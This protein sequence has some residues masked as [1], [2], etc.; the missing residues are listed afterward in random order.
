VVYGFLD[1]TDAGEALARALLH[2]RGRPDVIVLGL[3]RGGVPVAFEVASKLQLPLDVMVVRKLGLP[4]QPE[5]AMGALASGGG[6]VLN[7]DVLRYLPD[8]E[9]VLHLVQERE[10]LELTRR[11]HSYRGDRGA[12]QLS[13]LTVILVDD[14]LATGATMAAAVQS[15]RYLGARR[16]VVAVPVA[17]A[18]ARARITQIADEMLCL[19]TPTGF[20]AVGEW[21]R[22]F[23]QVD[24]DTVTDLL[25]Q[26]QGGVQVASAPVTVAQA[27]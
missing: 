4:A 6:R 15:A 25:S 10:L 14:G 16:V 27:S 24:D 18:A 13:G 19:Q 20:S 3:A 21:Y 5:V 11:E 22:Q 12:L 23:G 9:T 2:Y 1:R 17:S 26:V 8:R 7:E